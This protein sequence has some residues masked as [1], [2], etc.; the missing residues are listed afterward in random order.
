M[1]HRE[2]RVGTRLPN[3]ISHSHFE[4]SLC[5][6]VYGVIRGAFFEARALF[7]LISV[8][9][10][11]SNDE[12]QAVRANGMD[13]QRDRLWHVGDGELVEV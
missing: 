2:S 13:G 6:L 9:A 11:E 4:F 12:L 7:G 5:R 10:K 8:S 1:L 3:F